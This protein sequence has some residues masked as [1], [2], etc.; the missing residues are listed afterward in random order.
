MPNGHIRP[1]PHCGHMMP[2]WCPFLEPYQTTYHSNIG[3]LIRKVTEFKGMSTLISNVGFWYMCTIYCIPSGSIFPTRII[4]RH[5]H[6]RR[7]LQQHRGTHAALECCGAV[8]PYQYCEWCGGL[9]S[10][11]D[12]NVQC[13]IQRTDGYLFFTLFLFA[14]I[15]LYFNGQLR[16]THVIKWEWN[17]QVPHLI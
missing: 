12:Y 15:L 8:C 7:R 11:C 13:S 9:V 2:L 10:C 6:H 4:F 3:V 1:P 16:T 5:V 17:F 14:T